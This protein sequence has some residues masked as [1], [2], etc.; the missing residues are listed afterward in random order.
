LPDLA[1]SDFWL[2]DRIKS[3]LGEHLSAQSLVTDITRIL[4]SIDKKEFQ[5]TFDKWLERMDLCIKN[6]LNIYLN[7]TIN[8]LSYCHFNMQY[9]L[10]F[11]CPKYF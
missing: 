9:S 6:D 4:A 1:P 11:V 3:H 5:K 2:F 7:K 10:I 8:N